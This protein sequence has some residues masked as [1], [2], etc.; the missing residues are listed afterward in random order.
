MC[1]LVSSPRLVTS[2]GCGGQNQRDDLDIV[3]M[4]CTHTA[5]LVGAQCAV[6]WPLRAKTISKKKKTT[7]KNKTNRTR[8]NGGEMKRIE[9][10]LGHGLA[11]VSVINHKE[12]IALS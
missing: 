6:P 2:L 12:I 11:H 5:G 7:N 3:C 9:G 4:H 1:R 10:R 8:V